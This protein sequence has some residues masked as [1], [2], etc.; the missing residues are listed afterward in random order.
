MFWAFST[1]SLGTRQV[2]PQ[3]RANSE[4]TKDEQTPKLSPLAQS[5][6][7]DG[8]TVRVDIYEDGEVGWLLEV[9]DE[10]WNS[11][12]WDEPFASDRAALDEALKTIDEDGIES[13]IGAP[14]GTLS[15]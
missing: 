14:P 9:V 12:V 7:R 4:M 6:T 13:L 1:D 2:R 5:V 11:T 8:K 10:Y 15:H 3:Y